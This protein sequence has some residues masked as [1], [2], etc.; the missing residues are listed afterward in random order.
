MGG[1]SEAYGDGAGSGNVTPMDGEGEGRANLLTGARRELRTLLGR[2]PAIALP[3][4]RARGA[5]GSSLRF[6]QRR[7]LSSKDSRAQ[8]TRSPWPR[9]TW[10]RSPG[11]ADRPPRTRARAAS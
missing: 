3:L 4:L 1:R 2:Y 5:M 8:A 6:G 10:P 7:R 9:S 11:R